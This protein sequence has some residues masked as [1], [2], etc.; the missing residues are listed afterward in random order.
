[1]Y[2]NI[3]EDF[4]QLDYEKD[5]K[6]FDAERYFEEEG[7]EA[8]DANS[9]PEMLMMLNQIGEDLHLDEYSLKKLEIF[10]KTELPFF[11]VNRRLVRQW[12]QKNFV[13]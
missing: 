12:V 8:F 3:T 6:Q 2:L 7:H 4:L 13:Y 10:L 11:A 9:L 1:M 5:M